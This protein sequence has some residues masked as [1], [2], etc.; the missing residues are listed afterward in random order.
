MC[1][2]L[3]DPESVIDEDPKG[4]SMSSLKICTDQEKIFIK[5]I[6]NNIN[7]L[8]LRYHQICRASK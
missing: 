5:E 1:K 8:A 7:D 2:I 3:K 4:L 6:I